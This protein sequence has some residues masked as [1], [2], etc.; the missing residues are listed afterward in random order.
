MY[1]RIMSLNILQGNTELTVLPLTPTGKLWR[2]YLNCKQCRILR[3][4]VNGKLSAN[5]SYVDPTLSICPPDTK[6]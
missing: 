3:V 6:K 4:L 2:L 1:I 5:Y